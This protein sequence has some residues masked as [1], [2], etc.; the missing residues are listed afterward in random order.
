[1]D[2][3]KK[4]LSWFYLLLAITGGVLTMISNIEFMSQYG[5]GFDVRLFLQL[6]NINAAAQSLSRDLLVGSTAIFI[7]MIV[8]GRRLQIK[9]MLLVILSTFVVAFAFAAPLFLC[10]RERRLMELER[11]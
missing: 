5:P 7:W 4:L 2:Y 3:S 1:M 9:N 10:L 8:E 6:A 11:T